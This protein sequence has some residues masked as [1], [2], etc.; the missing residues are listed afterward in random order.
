MATARNFEVANSGAHRQ[1]RLP[2]FSDI[3]IVLTIKSDRPVLQQLCRVYIKNK[4]LLLV[5]NAAHQTFLKQSLASSQLNFWILMWS[6]KQQRG[7]VSVEPRWRA[8]SDWWHLSDRLLSEKKQRE[9]WLIEARCRETRETERWGW[10]EDQHVLRWGTLHWA[11]KTFVSHGTEKRPRATFRASLQTRSYPKQ[12]HFITAL[13]FSVNTYIFIVVVVF[14][15]QS[16]CF[17]RSLSHSHQ[18]A[19]LIR[20]LQ[21]KLSRSLKHSHR[22]WAGFLNN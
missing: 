8:C 5:R 3:K 12:Y 13:K 1:P 20:N 19:E 9:P 4:S 16:C 22:A 6:V 11:M 7:F 14:M 18:S 2:A 10:D 21:E 17:A 15:L